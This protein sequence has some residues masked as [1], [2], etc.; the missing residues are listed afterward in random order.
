HAYESLVNF[1]ADMKIVPALA[2][3]WETPDPTTYV[4][5]LRKGVKWHNGREFI[6]SDVVYW[7]ERMMDPATAAPYKSSYVGI[8]KVDPVD[9]YTVKTTLGKPNASLLALF[10]SLRGSAIPNKE[11]VQQYG[12]LTTHAVGTGPYKIVE[13]TPGDT[14]RYM[15]NP[16]YWDKG[17]PLIEEMTL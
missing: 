2:E 15:R 6:A 17:L 7:Y 11:T 1:D 4:F 5:H 3:S 16:D 8:T 9:N 14:V 12:D 13:F 10:A